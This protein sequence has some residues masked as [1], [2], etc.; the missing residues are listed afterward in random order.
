MRLIQHL[1][2]S[3][4]LV[5][6]AGV[7]QAQT[8]TS[9]AGEA[10]GPGTQIAVH[11]SGL[12]ATTHVRFHANVGGFVG[13]WTQDEPVQSAAADVVTVLVPDIVAGFVTV[14]PSAGGPFGDLQTVDASGATSNSLKFYFFEGTDGFLANAGLGTTQSTGQ[15][16]SILSFQLAG[17]APTPGN[18]TF[19]PTVHNA[20]P[21][22]M[23]FL[24]IG[25]PGPALPVD[26]GLLAVSLGGILVTSPGALV[27]G[28]GNSKLGPL[29]V[30][31]TIPAGVQLAMQWG[32]LDPLTFTFELSG[33]MLASY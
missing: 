31:A 21:G 5:C 15:G 16:R 18:P 2:P 22:A 25:L 19:T 14:G 23:P 32:Y 17:G 30:P 26:D 6:A 20:V 13:I 8:I 28:A 9:V 1:L 11:G 29:A 7:V 12:A 10:A 3:L 33:G 4:A 27:D 24:A